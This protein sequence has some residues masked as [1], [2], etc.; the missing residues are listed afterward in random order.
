MT[1]QTEYDSFFAAYEDE[2]DRE[3]RVLSRSSY[4]VRRI[5]EDGKTTV[6]IYY[7]VD[8]DEAL[9]ARLNAFDNIQKE[10]KIVQK[11][12]N[13]IMDCIK[14]EPIDEE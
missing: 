11:H 13:M 12:K 1:Y 14:E 8:V 7:L 9:Q 10:F 6:E 2:M 5:D 4:S 3:I